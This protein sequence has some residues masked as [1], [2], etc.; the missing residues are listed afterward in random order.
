VITLN[1]W[2]IPWSIPTVSSPDRTERFQA[3]G[4]FLSSGKYDFV[5][6]QE[7]WDEQDYEKLRKVLSESL[8]HSYYF[9][10]GTIGSGTCIFSVANIEQV[11][12][13]TFS[14][15]GFPHQVWR[16]DALAGSGVGAVQ[17]YLAEKKILL[18]VTHFHAEY[19]GEF[20]TDRAAQAWEA[21][22]F[23]KL[24][25]TETFDLLILA[26]DFNSLPG[27]LPHRILTS[28]LRDC[29]KGEYEITFANS[30]NSYAAKEAP[31]TLDYIFVREGSKVKVTS[32][33]TCLPLDN[34]IPSGKISFSDHEAVETEL[35]IE[36]KQLIP[37]DNLKELSDELSDE[38]VDALT[39]SIKTDLFKT[40][41][42]QDE[43]MTFGVVVA[44]LILIIHN[45][46]FDTILACI[47][48][49]C[50]SMAAFT[51]QTRKVALQNILQQIEL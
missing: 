36:N 41:G 3:I 4:E 38:V 1:C 43:Y 7:V 6:L 20:Q 13:H 16:G 2:G 40:Q 18:C 24:M 51:M 14:V 21:R 12:H 5:F 27:E 49:F 11:L 35:L 48:C 37:S 22:N 39:V 15:N 45:W 8:P 42:Y 50:F 23:V 29:W 25:D 28:C 31:E 19:Y 17:V 26:G 30:R 9:K 46:V 47:F 10:T 32:K 44:I 33:N 34:V